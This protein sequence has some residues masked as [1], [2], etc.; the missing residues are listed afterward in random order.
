M[1]KIKLQEVAE[2]NLYEGMFPHVTPPSICFE[3]PITEE[4]N[5]KT[6]TIDPSE[7]KTRDIHISDTTFRDGQQ[8]RPPYTA[9][10][11]VKLFE[12]ISRLSGPNGVIRQT[13]FFIYSKTDRQAVER[14]LELGLKFPEITSWIR[15][16]PE[17][18][19]LAVRVGL[20]ETGM[21]TSCSDYHIFH[22][23]KLDRKRAFE[24][25]TSLAK[26]AIQSGIRPRC[27]LEDVTR[28][29]LYGFVIPYVQE[30]MR[31]S[32]DVDESLKVKIRLC[33]TMGFG[34]S[35]P[36]VASPRSIP[37]LILAVI[38]EAGV[39][40]DRLEWHG[41]NDFHKVLVNGS[42]AWLYG[43]NALNGTLLGIG[44]RTGNPP[45]EGAIF[46][47][48]GLKGDM[49]GIDTAVL[50]E[51]ADYYRSIGT[52]VP[53]RAPFMGEDF[54]KTRAGI[55][56]DGLNR[57]ER[58]YNIFDTGKL[59]NRPPEVALTD[60]SGSDGVVLWVNNFLG[61]DRESRLG[62][63][64]VVKLMRWVVDQYDVHH[65]TTAISDKE[66]ADLVKKH[67]P[68]RYEQAQKEGRLANTNF[69][70]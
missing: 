26:E 29:D 64:K 14:C 42:T 59:L 49:C 53:A 15:A 19:N 35:Y 22:K 48:I 50:T 47:Y 68:K 6:Y 34:V 39:P 55:H 1:K 9:D 58:I 45:I 70:S 23:L 41:H 32:E 61:L 11:I 65:R 44:E 54:P 13:E 28:A 57:D 24:K 2:P 51:I 20:K 7:L 69:E 25:Y 56:A 30:L 60:K 4:L 38:N 5:G 52:H 18:I 17:D 62:K 36:S 63:T 40:G 31:I 37:K 3:G 33:D 12:L 43:C 46:E 27:H 67:L 21:L 10:Q 8:A 66:M 16:E